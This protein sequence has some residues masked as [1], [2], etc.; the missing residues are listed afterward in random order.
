[1]QLA[2]SWQRRGA[3]RSDA[4][5]RVSLGVAPRAF[6]PLRFLPLLQQAVVRRR[7]GPG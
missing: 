3:D 6:W 4:S 1:M 5:P 2:Y 7:S